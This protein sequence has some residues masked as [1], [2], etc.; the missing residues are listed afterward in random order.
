MTEIIHDERIEAARGRVMREAVC[1]LTGVTALYT[2]IYIGGLCCAGLFRW[3]LLITEAAAL[4]TGIVLVVWGELGYPDARRD[5][6][7][8]AA[9][10]RFYDRAFF[11]FAVTVAFA[12]C[13]HVA[14]SLREPQPNGVFSVSYF[15]STLL[16]L[17]G[18]FLLFRLKG[19]RVTLNYTVMDAAAGVYRRRVLWN[20]L[21]LGGLCLLFGCVASGV[22]LFLGGQD[23]RDLAG[24][25]LAA[26]ATWFCLGSVYLAVSAAERASDGA[27][28]RGRL[29]GVPLA[30]FF[31]HTACVVALAG[32]AVVSVLVYGAINSAKAAMLISYANLSFGELAALLVIFFALYIAAECRGLPAPC[33]RCIERAGRRYAL[34]GLLSSVISTLQ[35]HVSLYLNGLERRLADHEQLQSFIQ[36]LSAERQIVGLV[37]FT[38][39]AVCLISGL[40]SLARC[41]A[42]PQT[43]TAA[44]SGT[45]VAVVVLEGLRLLVRVIT[46]FEQRTFLSVAERGL[47]VLVCVLLGVLLVRMHRTIRLEV[48]T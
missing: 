40:W 23:L 33:G 8:A 9:Q 14:V 22:Y 18:V 46:V 42:L 32:L 29:S 2:L 31:G 1:F 6:M 48:E 41:K 35:T 38:L 28:R 37:I 43:L 7:A 34:I 10:G 26:A 21:R 36:I 30:T 20:T 45:T 11:G 47:S 17:G 27:E 13:V 5:E 16:S 19:K 39:G 12:Y 3:D 24:V 44:A 25:L 15:P 4:L